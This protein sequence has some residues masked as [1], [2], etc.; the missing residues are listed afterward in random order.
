MQAQVI[1][2]KVHMVNTLTAIFKF[3]VWNLFSI[4]VMMTTIIM[5]RYELPEGQIEDLSF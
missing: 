3:G 1:I 4:H 2:H 5:T